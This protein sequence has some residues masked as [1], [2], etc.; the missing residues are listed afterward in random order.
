M[1]RQIFMLLF[2]LPALSFTQQDPGQVPKLATRPAP[3]AGASKH[4]VT[5]YVRVTDKSGAPVRGLSQQDFTLF[6]DKH[7]QTITGFQAVEQRAAAAGYAPTQIVLVI[8]AVNASVTAVAFERDQIRKFLLRDGGAL[9]QPV[10]F[11]FVTDSGTKIGPDPSS[12]GKALL[13][14][15]NQ[16]ET[17]LR[18]VRHGFYQAEERLD[19]SMR[20]LATI[21]DYEEK[22]PGR[23]LVIWVSPGWPLLTGPNIEYSAR[24]RE[25]IFGEIVELSDLL[26][27]ARVTTYD[28]DPLGM[29]DAGSSQLTYYQNFVRGV[30]SP[31]RAEPADLALQVL[32]VQSGGR[33]LNSGNDLAGEIETCAADANSY[34]EISFD[35]PP[36]QKPVEYHDLAVKVDKPGSIIR[37]RTGYY[38]E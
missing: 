21:A 6:D 15:Y 17:G 1:G 37:T 36:R 24:G 5:L 33:V 9:S 3:D 31:S 2:L 35:Q 38:A 18:S 4:Q 20:A 22:R 25:Q 19:L 29:Q 7:P 10:S 34:Y 16:Y 26:R 8:D 12:D 13:T 11:A 30:S 14:L 32:A 28:V 23:K 27:E